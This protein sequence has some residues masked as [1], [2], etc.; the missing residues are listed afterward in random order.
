MLVLPQTIKTKWN[1]KHKAYYESKGYVYTKIRD[2]FEVN[3][4]DLPLISQIKVSAVCDYCGNLLHIGYGRANPG[5]KISC[6]HCR[7]KR[8]KEEF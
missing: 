7:P 3:V 1:S 5:K 6:K 2:E 8:M 4:L